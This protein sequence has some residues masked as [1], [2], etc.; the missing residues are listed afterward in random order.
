MQA[1]F[2]LVLQ[3]KIAKV[4]RRVNQKVIRLLEKVILRRAEGWESALVRAQSAQ[5]TFPP[6]VA[7]FSTPD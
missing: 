2:A 7:A 3:G 6:Q 4:I 5:A 1:Q